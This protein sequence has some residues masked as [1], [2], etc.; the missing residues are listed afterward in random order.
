[1]A[2][3]CKNKLRK[4]LVM[5]IPMYTLKFPS[6]IL[7]FSLKF[8]CILLQTYFEEKEEY[9]L[10]VQRRKV[11]ENSCYL[12]ANRLKNQT[13]KATSSCSDFLF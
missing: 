2:F 11:M 6:L 12:F 13:A 3:V 4:T 7:L 9:L 10:G 5:V 1:M 8:T